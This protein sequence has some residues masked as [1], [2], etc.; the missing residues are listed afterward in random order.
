MRKDDVANETDFLL[1][2]PLR[3]FTCFSFPKVDYKRVNIEEMAKMKVVLL[4]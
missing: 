1:E 4:I 2:L 3:E